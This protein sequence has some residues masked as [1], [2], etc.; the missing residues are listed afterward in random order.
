[1]EFDLGVLK[2]NSAEEAKKIAGFVAEHV[3]GIY[4]RKG[5]IV[6]LSGGVDSAVMAAIA[7]QA[8][9]QD[10]VVG[11]V[12]PESESNP[13]SRQY[14]VRHAEALGIEFREIDITWCQVII[15]HANTILH[16]PQIFLTGL[17]SISTSFR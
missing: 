17:P 2:I 12:L 11:L 1:M 5:V 9:G 15:P 6:G 16:Y 10:K 8:V 14:A 4:R 3:T 13:V 7:V